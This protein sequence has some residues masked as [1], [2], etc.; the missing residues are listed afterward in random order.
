MVVVLV[1]TALP[2]QARMGKA[3]QKRRKK[4]R[5]LLIKGK[6]FGK[7]NQIDELTPIIYTP[8]TTLWLENMEMRFSS[9]A[10]K[11]TVC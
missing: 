5:E 9:P 3:K 8:A 2:V 4:M 11:S 1:L 7:I 10:N 6:D